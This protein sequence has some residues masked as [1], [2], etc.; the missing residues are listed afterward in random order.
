MSGRSPASVSPLTPY[1]QVAPLAL[2]MITMVGIPLLTVVMLSFWE[3]DG[4]TV[5]PAFTWAN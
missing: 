3:F 1:L 2:L 5:Y 4:I